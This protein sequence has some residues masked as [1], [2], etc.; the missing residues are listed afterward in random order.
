MKRICFSWNRSDCGFGRSS[1]RFR[2]ARGVAADIRS[3][4]DIFSGGGSR[5]YSG[6]GS[7]GYYGGGSRGYYGGGSRGVY[8]RREP[9][10]LRAVGARVSGPGRFFVRHDIFKIGAMGRADRALTPTASLRNSTYFLES[11]AVLR[12]SHDCFQTRAPIR[13]RAH[14]WPPVGRPA[15]RQET[16][17]QAL[18]NNRE[19]VVARESAG[20]PPELGPEP[21][22]L[23]ARTPLP[24]FTTNAWFIYEPLL[25]YPYGYG[26]GY[27]YGY[28]YDGYYDNSYYDNGSYG[29]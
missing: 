8:G 10:I 2:P 18:N 13:P 24:L 4:V 27:G 15:G 12:R 22:S 6:G 5:G 26:Y 21:R 7:R 20:R 1:N 11:L 28:P 9:G 25:W 23:V 29:R 16:R 17:S 14:G 3:L 19:R